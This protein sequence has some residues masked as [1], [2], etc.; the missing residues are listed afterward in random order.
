[1]VN[2]SLNGVEAILLVGGP[3]GSGKTTI[4][5]QL[6][7]APNAFVLPA[8]CPEPL[9][10]TDWKSL[11]AKRFQGG[12]VIVEFATNKLADPAHRHIYAEFIDALGKAAPI[13]AGYTAQI[14][15]ST[16]RK[17]YLQRMKPSHFLHV[18]KW[19]SLLRYLVS[20]QS[21]DFGLSVWTDLLDEKS[22]RQ[23]PW[24]IPRRASVSTD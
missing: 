14:S 11:T 15:R 17:R 2:Q 8:Q 7:M 6:V 23:M 20:P 10:R 18:G 21:D 13:R 1:M 24:P 19:K 12:T 16:L 22:I 9:H 3:A 4:A 5:E